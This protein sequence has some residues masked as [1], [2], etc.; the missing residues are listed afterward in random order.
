MSISRFS[1][2][3]N[4]AIIS[5]ASR[6]I[7]AAI[8][9]TFAEAG[10]NLVICA[11]SE[12]DLKAL[13]E[14]LRAYGTEVYYVA[15]DL[16][17]PANMKLLAAE[18]ITRLGRID[19]VVNNV[20]GANPAPF[21]ETSASDLEN[22][23]A[24]NVSTAHEL[25]KAS[26]PYLLQAPKDQGKAGLLSSPSVINISSAYGHR[27][28]KGLLAYGTAKSALLHWTRMAA[29]D[30]SPAIRVNSIAA[31][32]IASSATEPILKDEALRKKFEASSS[33]A[34]LGTTEDVADGALYLASPAANY[35]TG[36]VLEIDGGIG[37]RRL[38]VG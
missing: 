13:S 1:L 32:I 9:Q 18:A 28:G 23:F 27:V 5:G 19:I 36:I 3:N 35:V 16:S 11:R 10:A 38:D 26:L 31:G 17:N 12:A 37:E 33:Q 24:F 22:A 25:T 20:G 21:L 8:A 29:I 14:T 15:L 7:G 34:R 6:G 2:K 30:L 4:V